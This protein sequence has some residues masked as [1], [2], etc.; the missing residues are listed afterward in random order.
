MMNVLARMLISAVLVAAPV[1]TAAPAVAV[2]PPPV[3][4]AMLPAPA[5]AA[6]ALPTE[7]SEPCVTDTVAAPHQ[8]DVRPDM[9]SRPDLQSAWIRTRGAGQTVAVIDTGVARHRLLPHLV[10]GGDY[11]AGGDGTGDCDGHGTIV[12]G[13]IG[14]APDAATGFSGIAPD[15][16]ILG[17]RQSSTK[18]RTAGAAGGGVGDVN[19]LAMA[20]RSAADQGATVINI[21]SVACLGIDDALDDR[22]LGAALAYA[23]DVRNA[24]VVAAAGNVGG[25]GTCPKQNPLPEPAGTG[26]PDWDRVDV[27]ASPSWY[28]D[29]VLTV[30]SVDAEGTPSDFTLAGPWVDVAAVG[31]AVV[32][33]SAIGEGLVDAM[34]G[35]AEPQPISGTSYAAPAVSG[36][37]A[38]VR[39]LA[40]QLTARQVMHR[41]ES[42]ARRPASGWNP[43]VGNGVVDI[44]AAVHGITGPAPAAPPR[45]LDRKPAEA[46][47]DDSGR[48]ALIG[49]GLCVVLAVGAVFIP[50]VRSRRGADDGVPQHGSTR[51]A[52]LGSAR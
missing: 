48:F 28:D 23:V 41:I 52:E 44:L 26:Q 36:I 50:T 30:G 20:V 40:P 8:T 38:L 3:D 19:S 11:V 6:P 46:T 21:S 7:Q 51:D 25:Q 45:P 31:Q 27:V 37:A 14:A 10:P 29:F 35:Q 47:H 13:I 16:T 22:A 24:V 49:A 34:P 42:T 43:L 32:S 33:L 12:A 15:V 17:I 5:P 4:S 9:Q 1:A 39:A 18:F 2:N